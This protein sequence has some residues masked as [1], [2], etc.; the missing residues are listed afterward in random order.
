MLYLKTRQLKSPYDYFIKEHLWIP[1][2][3]FYKCPSCKK[4]INSNLYP[5]NVDTIICDCGFEGK[6]LKET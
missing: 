2:G 6:L 1:L 5:T 4:K 3:N